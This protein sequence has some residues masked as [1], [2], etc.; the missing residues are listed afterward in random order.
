VPRRRR[1]SLDVDGPDAS[2]SSRPAVPRD[3]EALATDDDDFVVLSFPLPQD[4]PE[5]LTPAESEVAALVIAGRTN[6]EIA[7]LRGT[8][9]RTVANQM[10]SLFRKLGVRSRLQLA[11]SAPLLGPRAGRRGVTT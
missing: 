9:L 7:A 1:R 2:R 10:A 3:L 4:P 11:T 5:A 8:T 6:G